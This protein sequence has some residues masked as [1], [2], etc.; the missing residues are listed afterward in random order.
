MPPFNLDKADEWFSQD[1]PSCDIVISTRARYARNLMDFPFSPRAKPPELNSICSQ[2]E[3]VLQKTGETFT[4]VLV[5]ELDDME[6]QYLKESHLISVEMER[7]GEG[8]AVFFSSESSLSILVNEE[9]HLRIQCLH[10]GLQLRETLEQLDALELRLDPL[11]NYAYHEQF[12]Y[13]TACPTNAGTGLRISV[14]MH[15]PALVMINNIEEISQLL[16]QFGLTVRGFYGENSEFLGDFFQISNEISLGKTEQ[17]ILEDLERVTLQIMEREKRARE[18]L[19]KAKRVNVEDAVWRAYGT[20]TNSRLISSRDALKLL[21]HLRL[22]IDERIFGRLEHAVLNRL[23]IEV[24][25]AHLQH[26]LNTSLNEEDRDSSRAAY[27][28]TRLAELN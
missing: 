19:F 13:L 6:R 12:G 24:Q 18:I 7:G 20:L 4:Q 14:M 16:P 23:M 8:R 21:S 27:L 11:L 2:V 17:Q 10:A 1:A 22:A 3:Q 25:P 26:T 28:R 5:S 9:D 15:L